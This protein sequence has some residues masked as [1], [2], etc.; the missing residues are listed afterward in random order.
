MGRKLE[1]LDALLE[2]STA[3]CMRSHGA[4]DP[5]RSDGCIARR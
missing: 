3:H 2:S 5:S 1:A 4:V